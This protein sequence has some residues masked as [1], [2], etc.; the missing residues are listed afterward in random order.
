MREIRQDERREVRY[1]G[2]G[3]EEGRSVWKGWRREREGD[4][5]EYVEGSGRGE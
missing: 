3:Q 1:E 2:I 4:M 5:C